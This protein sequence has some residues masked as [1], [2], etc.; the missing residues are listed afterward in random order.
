MQRLIRE[1]DAAA[2]WVSGR[3]DQE[4]AYDDVE[5]PF[6][7]EDVERLGGSMYKGSMYEERRSAT[8]L[9][10]SFCTSAN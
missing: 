8:G 3:S 7:D 10:I 5:L 9:L 1:K 2:L 4:K 6:T